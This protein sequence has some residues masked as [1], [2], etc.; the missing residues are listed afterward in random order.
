[1]SA[2]VQAYTPN[3]TR[4]PF[5][6]K[7][8]EQS[9]SA[10]FEEQVSRYP[11]RTAV[12]TPNVT[13]TYSAL[14]QQANRIA[15]AIVNQCGTEQT[16][17][18]HFVTDDARSIAAILG[19]LKAGKIY[20]TLDP[21]H[22][23]ARNLQVLNTA[24]AALVITD[25]D[26]LEAAR[27]LA[28]AGELLNVDAIPSNVGDTNLGLAIPPDALACIFFTSGSTGQPKGV[29][30]SQ[31]NLLAWA[32]SYGRSNS[33]SPADRICVISAG[34]SA[35]S[36][37]N[38]FSAL[39]SGAAACPF[40]VGEHGP[41]PLA[42]WLTDEEITIYHSSPSVFRSLV[43]SLS[44]REEFPRLRALR[45]GGEIV[46]VADFEVYKKHFSTNC[47]FLSSFGATETGTFREF[48]ANHNTTIS[49]SLVPSGYAAWGTDVLILDDD[50]RPAGAGSVGEIAVRGEYLALSYWRQP[51]LT[52]AAFLPDPEN[53]SSRIYRTGDLGRL[54]PDGCLHCL[55]RKDRQVKIRGNRVEL[56]DVE[57][58][59]RTI[60]GVRDTAITI[61]RNNQ[62]EPCIVGYVVAATHPGPSTISL[63]SDLRKLLPD[64]M[65]P[66]I[67]VMLD[68]IPMTSHGKVDGEALPEPKIERVYV[69]PRNAAESLMCVLWQQVL[70]V[71]S[72][73]IRDGFLE[74]GGNSLLAARLMNHIE[75][76]FGRRIPLSTL[77]SATTVEELARTIPEQP[78][79]EVTSPLVRMQVG[80]TS[81]KPFFFL[82]GQFS[83]WGLY[84]KALA[85][86][87]GEEQPFYV[88]H[89]LA[90]RGHDLPATVELMAKRYV[91]VLREAQPHGPYLLGGYC[92]AGLIAFEM[93]QQL[94][95]QGEN[96]ELLV[97]V[98]TLARNH[99]FRPHRKLVSFAAR[100]LG[101]KPTDELE[102]FVRLC[103]L[104]TDFRALPSSER[105]MFIARSVGALPCVASSAMRRLL[106]Q[107]FGSNGA[108][109][110]SQ[111]I[112]ASSDGWGEEEVSTHYRR[113]VYG[114]VPR[115]YAGRVTIF[116]A[117]GEK[118]P[119]DDPAMGWR[120]LA[121]KVDSHSIPGDHLGC[122]SLAENLP[123]LA[124]HLKS[125]LDSFHG[126]SHGS[127][128]RQKE[129][130]PLA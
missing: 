109:S 15:R 35:Q 129:H 28:G 95:A 61:R 103:K 14:N 37:A 55:G 127:D 79:R 130:L 26:N 53:T 38:I 101:M 91:Q 8:L 69:P 18:A 43:Q 44:G 123:I 121:Q 60:E 117:E 27:E 92:N 4:S 70:G 77:L 64:Y 116:R 23:H 7:D 125:C 82:H 48:F 32:L 3:L 49:G 96:V 22:P 40:R 24:D 114:Y 57:M 11:D 85:P 122:I 71:R 6:K 33:L 112:A 90:E 10:R 63:R 119:T 45:L 1:M 46:S 41:G 124:E 126:A 113:L 105:T 2:R 100:F 99:E 102:Y 75:L 20:L 16:Q 58:T 59:L 12:R 31:R 34:T 106:G 128:A 5:E 39:L 47:I 76:H 89:P 51:D 29:L 108:S 104:S 68:S 66:S 73:G 81:R 62:G 13:L 86:F 67:F 42:S 88:F 36:M 83:G 97:L 110:H 30:H 72:V 21:R 19:I 118:H 87:L 56:A 78:D 107:R 50:G 80:C 9:V 94:R 25:N 52:R 65:V 115:P 84:C 74:L 111:D 120:S 17:V 98:E 54:S 93:A